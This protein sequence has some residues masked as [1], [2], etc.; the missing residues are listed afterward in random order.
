[1]HISLPKIKIKLNKKN[2]GTF[3]SKGWSHNNDDDGMNGNKNKR[4]KKIVSYSETRVMSK[5]Q[6]EQR[7]IINILAKQLIKK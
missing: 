2:V 3:F 5:W 1:M 6:Q 7:H 4:R